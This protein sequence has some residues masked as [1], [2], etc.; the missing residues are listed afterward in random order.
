[1]ISTNRPVAASIA[2]VLAGLLSACASVPEGAT[3]TSRAVGDGIKLLKVQHESTVRAF[4]KSARE[5]VNHVWD[6]Q[7]LDRVV[8]EE[9]KRGCSDSINCP[10]TLTPKQ[11]ATAAATAADIR[12]KL[13]DKINTHEAK[14]MAAVEAN[15]RGVESINNVVT[16][17]LASLEEQKA[18][19]DELRQRLFRAAGI[20]D[21]ELPDSLSVA[22]SVALGSAEQPEAAE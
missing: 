2:V 9:R 14:L 12:T 21:S 3:A 11:A 19:T 13:I 10:K 1:M 22:L 16:G 7:I 15:Y 8:D 17:Y 4:A 6:T 20:N 5:A 18:A